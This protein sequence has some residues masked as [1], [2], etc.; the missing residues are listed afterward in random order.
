MKQKAD[1]ILRAKES[2]EKNRIFLKQRQEECRRKEEEE[3]RKCEEEV[4]RHYRIKVARADLEMKLA[5]KGNLACIFLLVDHDMYLI[6]SSF[7]PMSSYSE[8]G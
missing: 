5:K 8:F 1:H 7:S 4:A 6:L 3:A 2:M